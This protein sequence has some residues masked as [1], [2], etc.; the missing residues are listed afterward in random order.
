VLHQ[1][2]ATRRSASSGDA[3][4]VP[5]HMS[6]SLMAK[7]RALATPIAPELCGSRP[8]QL[9]RGRRED[10]APAGTHGPRAAKVARGRTTGSAEN[11]RP[12]PRNGFNSVFRA[13]PGDHRLVA[14]VIPEK[15]ASQELSACFGAPGPHGLAVR[16]RV[17]RQLPR[18]R[19][20]HPCPTSVTI[21]IR[22][23][24]RAGTVANIRLI[25]VSEKAKYFLRG[26]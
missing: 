21:A 12:S 26:D 20:P 9:K 18:S 13:L 10:R 1:R 24:D 6:K 7:P 8:L 17:S 5:L 16:A 22:P 19:P 15:P 11:T 3:V 4:A 23:S 25:W 2:E 14:T